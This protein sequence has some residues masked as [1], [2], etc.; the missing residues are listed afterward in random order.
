MAMTRSRS[1]SLSSVSASPSLH[2]PKRS[3]SASLASSAHSSDDELL[4]DSDIANNYGF[5]PSTLTTAKCEWGDCQEEF[6]E[7]E[8]LVEHIHAVHAFPED[9][10]HTAGSKRAAATYICDWVGCPR[11]G[12]TQGSKFALVAHLR[13]HTGEKPFNCPRPE[14]DKSF[15]RT[16][17]L[18]KHMRVQHGDK[19][20]A[21]RR[22][23]SKK[24]KKSARAGS[25]DSGFGH[26]DDG[27]STLADGALDGDDGAGG[28]P[29]WSAEELVAFHQ[30]QDLSQEFVSYV[31]MKAKWAYLVGEHEGMANELEALQAREDELGMEVQELV[32]GVMSKEVGST[33]DQGGQ[34]LLEQYLTAYHH[35]PLALPP[36]WTSKS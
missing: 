5:D 17:A 35:E 7:L 16:D 8:P 3:R 28:E 6:W 34:Q 4:S 29:Q 1:S 25:E 24:P 31:L 26:D 30:H 22:P 20:V 36:D 15:T 32:A 11:R 21:A 13:S 18:Q 33:E 23:P 9:A 12:K 10:A 2:T 19:I 14:C 27:A